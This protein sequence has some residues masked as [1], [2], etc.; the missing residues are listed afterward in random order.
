MT[1]GLEG[2][3]ILVTG[4]G[5]GIGAATSRRLAEEGARV[6][7]VDLDAELAEATAAGM[8]GDA[9]A[10][11]ADV[12]SEDGVE[13]YTQAALERF[14]RIDGV[15]LNAGITGTPTPLAD[16]TFENWNRVV[17]VNLTGT[18]L[19][20]RAAL[21]VMR[22]QGDGG[23]IVSTAST[24]GVTGSATF[25]TYCATKHGVVGLVR[26]A[27][28]EGA[29]LGIR[30][31]AICPSA[32]DTGMARVLEDSIGGDRAAARER[33]ERANPLRRYATPEEVAALAAWLLSDEASYS[34]GGCF[35]VDGGRTAGL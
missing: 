18:Y 16:S 22:D 2:K 33:F 31:N 17:A 1:V 30:V 35:M 34:S 32:T 27:A 11:A 25:G 8:P 10:V 24:G 3:V 19:G 13:R 29:A 5:R 12:S 9:L 20:L 4:A 21:R 26:S 15:H 23:S 6:V 28:L 14:G 7:V